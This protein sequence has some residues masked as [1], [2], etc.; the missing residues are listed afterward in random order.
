MNVNKPHPREVLANDYSNL[1][2]GLIVFKPIS[3]ADSDDMV[4]RF[5]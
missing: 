4:I 1:K 2:V 5:S 3:R